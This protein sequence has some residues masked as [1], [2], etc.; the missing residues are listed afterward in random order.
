MQHLHNPIRAEQAQALDAADVADAKERAVVHYT[1]MA[2][3]AERIAALEAELQTVRSG[4]DPA[5]A[6]SDDHSF[7][8]RQ[9]AK[10]K[11][12]AEIQGE[13]SRVFA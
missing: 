10:A 3:G 5:Y 1:R 2:S 6:Y 11:R 8:C 7:F 9:D 13:L 4:F 12:I